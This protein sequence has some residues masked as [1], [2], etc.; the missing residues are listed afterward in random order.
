MSSDE[1]KWVI[2]R[3]DKIIDLNK[4]VLDEGSRKFHKFTEKEIA[5][6][7]NLGKEV[8]SA[9]A[10][11]IS[12]VLGLSA[13]KVDIDVIRC[14]S[15][16]LSIGIPTYIITLFFKDRIEHIL[17]EVESEM[18][19]GK[20]SLYAFLEYFQNKAS[21]V[22][23][24]TDYAEISDFFVKV[25]IPSLNLGEYFALLNTTKS[26][27]KWIFL[28]KPAMKFIDLRIASL[29]KYLDAISKSYAQE[30]TNYESRRSLE[31]LLVFGNALIDYREKKETIPKMNESYANS[32]SNANN[33]I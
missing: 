9:I 14:I 20:N 3:L 5:K 26:I 1:N 31:P 15:C 23:D 12:L 10:F 25:I 11:L 28:S 19:N 17:V 13:A 29:K 21:V 33:I 18:E 6:L 27:E 4:R 16:I 24:S 2:E 32:A 7:D 22:D 30:K 8:I